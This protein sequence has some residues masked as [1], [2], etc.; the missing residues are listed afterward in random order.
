METNKHVQWPL[1][2]S[3]AIDRLEKEKLSIPIAAFQFWEQK[4][5]GAILREIMD[6]SA[7]Y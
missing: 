1:F 4:D 5:F 2:T 3:L 6:K 7:F